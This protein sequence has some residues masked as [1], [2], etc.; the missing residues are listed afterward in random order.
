[1]AGNPGAVDGGIQAAR[2]PLLHPKAR[3]S[4]RTPL[5]A[6]SRRQTTASLWRLRFLTTLCATPQV[7]DLCVNDR[8]SSESKEDVHR[9][10][11]RRPG[12]PHPIMDA[13]DE[14]GAP[15]RRT[16]DFTRG[17]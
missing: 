13:R 11:P 10:R 4:P 8:A 16:R 14:F 17:R 6:L 15:L 3:I 1:M 12:N 9:Y 5:L 2:P 7:E